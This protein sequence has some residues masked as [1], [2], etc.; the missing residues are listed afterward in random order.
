[1]GA[2]T[3]GMDDHGIVGIDAE[4]ADLKQFAIVGGPHAHRE[5]VIEMPLRDGVADRVEHVV[6][7]DAVLSSRLRDAHGMT[8]YLVGLRLSRYLVRTIC[9][10]LCA[11]QGC[12][13]SSTACVPPGQPIGQMGSAEGRCDLAAKCRGIDRRVAV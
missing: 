10:A 7:C 4:D 12:G 5:I 1:M 3:H 13:R 11:P 9:A 2:G 6:I 8:R